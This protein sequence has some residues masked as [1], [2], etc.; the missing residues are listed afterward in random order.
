MA[1]LKFQADHIFTGTEILQRNF[2]LITNEKGMIQEIVASK[3]AGEDV[4][5][6][7]GMLTPGFVNCHCHLEL[8]HMKG[9]IPSRTGL[10]DFLITVIK[11]RGAAKEFIFD[12]MR[13]AEQELYNSGTVAVGDICNTTDTIG[14]KQ[15]SKLRFYNFLESL[16]FTETKAADR[17]AFAENTA[18][19]FGSLNNECAIVPHA[20]YSVSKQLFDLINNASTGKTIS[21]HNQESAAEEDLYKTGDSDF[22]RL[23][24]ALGID[25]SFFKASGKSSLQTYL[26][27]L[28]NARNLILV[29]DTY[30]SEEDLQITDQQS[31]ITNQ[32]VFFCLCPNANLYIEGKMP[33]VEIMRKNNCNMVIGTDSYAS[34]RS[35]NMLDEIRRIQ[36][37]SAFSIPTAEILQ[38]ATH[39]GA[40]ALQMDDK[41]GSFEKGK[42]PGVVLIDELSN[43]YITTK[44]T[45]KRI[46]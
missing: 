17:F 31:H 39:N 8:S 20:P 15:K 34:N 45:A 38:W 33:P 24:S 42:S 40:K 12:S 30:T 13:Q 37:E 41:L 29:H 21:I 5:H 4:Q 23:Y 3:E 44:S 9:K 46:I 6:F 10:V 32:Q 11:Q 43:Q 36:H 26:P 27:W 16:G 1:Y 22:K 35:L 18:E 19:Q 7:K 25:A 28:N 2:V 14:F